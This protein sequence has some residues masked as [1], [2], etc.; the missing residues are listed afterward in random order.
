MLARR[1][2]V[3]AFASLLNACGQAHDLKPELA[4]IAHPPSVQQTGLQEAAGVFG[5]GELV[6]SLRFRSEYQ[7]GSL[8]KA[9]E[10]QLSKAGWQI[11]GE[12]ASGKW[13][14]F[15]DKS[16]GVER[17]KSQLTIQ[18][19]K[20]S[21]DGEVRLEQERP[22]ATPNQVTEGIGYLRITTPPSGSCLKKK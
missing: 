10:Q 5:R 2:G 11:C 16:S 13:I 19:S 12:S 3:T 1:I 4:K 9:Y 22:N 6:A 20:D 21:F 15:L 8:A 18:F 7:T 17:S 14:E